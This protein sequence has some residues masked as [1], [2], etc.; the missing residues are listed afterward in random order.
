[1]AD[2]CARTGIQQPGLEL[3]F[4]GPRVVAQSK[5]APFEPDDAAQPSAMLERVVRDSPSCCLIFV[6]H[7][8]LQR[9]KFG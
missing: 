2:D 9:R 4:P 3:R 6:K 8:V 7:P 5:D 1:V